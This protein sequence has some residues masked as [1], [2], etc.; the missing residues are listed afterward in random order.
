MTIK[1][2]L[3]DMYGTLDGYKLHQI[4]GEKMDMKIQFYNEF[5]DVI[6]K[7]DPGLTKVRIMHDVCNKVD[8]EQLF[9]GKKNIA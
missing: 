8:T 5:L 1:K 3:A 9:F 4:S 2:Y 6:G 7:V